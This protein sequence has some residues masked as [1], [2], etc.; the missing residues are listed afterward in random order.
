[1]ELSTAA[2]LAASGLA[3]GLVNAIAGG[4]TLTKSGA[5]TLT[6]TAG[7]TNHSTVFVNDGMLKLGSS[8]WSGSVIPPT[9]K[10]EAAPGHTDS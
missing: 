7:N 2:L 1:M 4:G 9:P 6:L 5:G 3:A 8:S 10:G